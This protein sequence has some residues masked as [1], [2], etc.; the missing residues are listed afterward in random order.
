M[1]NKILQLKGISVK[2]PNLR[3]RRT[4]C[5]ELFGSAIVTEWISQEI[6]FTDFNY[7]ALKHAAL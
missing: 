5:V 7:A 1:G 3:Y 6:P 2:K 4:V